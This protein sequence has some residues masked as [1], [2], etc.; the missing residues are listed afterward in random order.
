MPISNYPVSQLS[1]A[2][3]KIRANNTKKERA[4][5]IHKVKKYESQWKLKFD[6][7]Q[8]SQL[9]NIMSIIDEQHKDELENILSSDKSKLLRQEW[10]CDQK[11]HLDFCKDQTRNGNKYLM[12]QVQQHYI[13]CII[14]YMYMYTDN[15]LVLSWHS[16]ALHYTDCHGNRYNTLPWQ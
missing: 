12:I 15:G 8:S 16:D 4:V 14:T 3:Q 5:G 9:F 6:D 13:S 7:H 10:E 11:E 2:S 1:P